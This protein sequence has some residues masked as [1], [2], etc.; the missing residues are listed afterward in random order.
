MKIS[1]DNKKILVN[2]IDFVISQMEKEE[3]PEIKMYYY[4]AT[5][6]MMQRILNIEYD[7]H[8]EYI[9]LVVSGAYSMIQDRLNRMKVGEQVIVLIPDFFVL[10]EGYLK[11]LRDCINSDKDAY[12]TLEKILLLA[13]LTTG[14]GYYRYQKGMTFL[15]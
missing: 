9:D 10:L 5:F 12:K 3:N 15:K 2:E 8:L 4:S 13:N 1:S 14:N 7:S 6:T 11:E